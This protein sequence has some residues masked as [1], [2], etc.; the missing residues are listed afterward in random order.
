MKNFC[1]FT[2]LLFTIILFGCQSISSEAQIDSKEKSSLKTQLDE[3]FNVLLD[4][5]QF[6]GVVLV[7]KDGEVILRKAYNLTDNMDSSLHVTTA[8]QFDLRSISKQ[9][10]KFSI[11]KLQSAGKLSIH[12]PIGKYLGEF[13]NSDKITLK[14]LI[15][16]QSGLPREFED[17][18]ALNIFDMEPAKIVELIKKEPLEFEPG[19]ETQ[20]SNL[21][22]QLVYYIIGQ[23]TGQTFAQHVQDEVYNPLKMTSSGAHFYTDKNNLKKFAAYHTKA[24]DGVI[25]RIP[26]HEKGSK[27]Q[28]KLY[29]TIDDLNK[30][31][32]AFQQEPYSKKMASSTGIIGHSGGSEGIRSHFQTNIQKNYSFIFLANYDG[33]PFTDIIKTI[34]KIVE[35]KP[36]DIPVELKRSP[37]TL[38]ENQLQKYA[39]T[40]DFKDANHITFNFKIEDGKLTAYQNEEFRGILYPENDSV[41]F[42]AP[43]DAQSV[44]FILDSNGD[45]KVMMDMFGAP[46]EGTKVN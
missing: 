40:Y 16:N 10:A 2:F 8:H 30:L 4:L 21:G 44:K 35:G 23:V 1:Q 14:H 9:I 12:D 5:K 38:S 46:W 34:E 11:E 25:V 22:F 39:G 20:Y 33:I 37:I 29:S 43:D 27:K 19:T 7:E 41:F 18:D 26:H 36:Y 3:Y 6:N 42:W 24:D 32:H 45:Y 13:P 17:E 28:A 15:A 31:L